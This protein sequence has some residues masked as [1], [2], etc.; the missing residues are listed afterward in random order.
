MNL[1]MIEI[2]IALIITKKLLLTLQS[3][4]FLELTKTDKR[5]RLKTR[6]NIPFLKLH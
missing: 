3:N 1:Q 2:I 6:L 4:V 5:E